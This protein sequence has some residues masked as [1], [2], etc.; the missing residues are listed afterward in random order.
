MSPCFA[1]RA[2]LLYA[3]EV[4][5]LFFL[6]VYRENT[7]PALLLNLPSNI[8]THKTYDN[9]TYYKSGDIGQVSIASHI[10][11]IS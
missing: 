4:G 8:E 1:S 6:F 2:E 5:P 7:Y 3:E 10:I 11:D 9:I